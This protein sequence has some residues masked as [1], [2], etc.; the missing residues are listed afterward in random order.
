MDKITEGVSHFDPLSILMRLPESQKNLDFIAF[1]IFNYFGCLKIKKHITYSALVKLEKRCGMIRQLKLTTRY[2][3]PFLN[4]K[5]AVTT[6]TLK[7]DLS[8]GLTGAI[9]VLPQGVAFAMIAGLPPVYGLYTAM[10]TPIVAALFGSSKHLISGPTTP[11]SLIIFGAV[12]KLA[13]PMSAQFIQ[14]TLV[15]TFVAGLLQL[16]MGI[17]RLGM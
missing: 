16:A 8:A 10:V 13:E 15:I 7:A 2:I 11:V 14:L 1:N 5:N 4:W 9:I 12:S 3:F 6:E 17:G